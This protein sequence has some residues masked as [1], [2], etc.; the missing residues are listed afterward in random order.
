MQIHVAAVSVRVA[1]DH[2][3]GKKLFIRF[4]VR[5]FRERLS[6]SVRVLLSLL[7]LRVSCPTGSYQLLIIVFLF[8]FNQYFPCK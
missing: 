5:V 1:D 8:T 2:L 6:F 4:N 7:V 3:F